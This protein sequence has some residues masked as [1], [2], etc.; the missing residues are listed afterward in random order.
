MTN[1]DER[2]RLESNLRNALL[3]SFISNEDD[4]ILSAHWK[5]SM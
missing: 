2:S 3:I 5:W 1:L 4:I